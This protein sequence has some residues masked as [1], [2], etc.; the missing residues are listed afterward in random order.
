MEAGEDTA[1]PA[2]G[3]AE[4][5][6]DTR[7]PSEEAGDGGGLHEDPA[8]LGEGSLEDAGMPFP[9]PGLRKNL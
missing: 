2:P 9:H 7:F 4:D 3:D 5:L 6:E 1:A 8:D